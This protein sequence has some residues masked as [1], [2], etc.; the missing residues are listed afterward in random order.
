MTDEERTLGVAALNE[1]ATMDNAQFT[2]PE[3]MDDLMVCRHGVK[4]RIPSL[5]ESWD[6]YHDATRHLSAF[7][8]IAAF[9]DGLHTKPTFY[10]EVVV[11]Y[12][13]DGDCNRNPDLCEIRMQ[14]F[15][16]K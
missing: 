11:G 6:I 14:R 15:Y 3:S 9:N 12:A 5:A 13:F 4:V 1:Y 16:S 2:R 8:D 7:M 10:Q